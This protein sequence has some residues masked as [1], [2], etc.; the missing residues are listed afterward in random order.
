MDSWNSPGLL[1]A[2]VRK[3]RGLML[4]P[5]MTGCGMISSFLAWIGGGFLCLQ[6]LND[7]LPR[8]VLRRRAVAVATIVS[9]VNVVGTVVAPMAAKSLWPSFL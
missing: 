1:I 8:P 6:A 5:G 2:S 3:L 4:F 9:A 7:F